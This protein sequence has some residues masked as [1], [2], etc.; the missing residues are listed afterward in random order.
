MTGR[1]KKNN[2]KLNNIEEKKENK[3]S[4]NIYKTYKVYPLHHMMFYACLSIC[5]R[6]KLTEYFIR[7]YL[8]ENPDLLPRFSKPQLL[9]YMINHIE[10]KTNYNLMGNSN[11]IKEL[12]QLLTENGLK[13]DGK[14]IHFQTFASADT[15]SK[16]AELSKTTDTI[17]EV[18]E[19][20]IEN[21]IELAS[22]FHFNLIK[23]AFKYNFHEN[24]TK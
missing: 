14:R 13:L 4:K 17:G 18:I 16:I 20:A 10:D 5:T 24:N 22:E 11:R 15:H 12:S 23:L 21:Y 6:D 1:I 7:E 2:E 3:K 19:L 8:N 9:E